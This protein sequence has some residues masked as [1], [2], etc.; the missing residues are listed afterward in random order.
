MR[1][2]RAAVSNTAKPMVWKV[3]ACLAPCPMSGRSSVLLSHPAT[4]GATTPPQAG[5]A[6][7]AAA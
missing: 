6:P 1:V 3:R 7:Q 5:L 2:F 4:L